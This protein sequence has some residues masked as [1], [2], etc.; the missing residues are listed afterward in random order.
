MQPFDFIVEPFGHFLVH[1]I[2]D[3]AH[4]IID[5]G[6]DEAVHRGVESLGVALQHRLFTL[7]EAQEELVL[8]LL[9]PLVNVFHPSFARLL[10][11]HCF[12]P[13]SVDEFIIQCPG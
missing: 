12:S 6:A 13:N 11:C 4:V 10:F 1:I 3:H 5:R 9:L 8:M 2:F 7:G